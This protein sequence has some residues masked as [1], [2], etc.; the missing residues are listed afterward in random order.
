MKDMEF[1][2]EYKGFKIYKYKQDT[3]MKMKGIHYLAYFPDGDLYDGT[4]TVKNMRKRI[5][6]F[7]PR[8]WR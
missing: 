3:Y 7:Y 8:T 4:D 5:D 1:V 6:D 2:E